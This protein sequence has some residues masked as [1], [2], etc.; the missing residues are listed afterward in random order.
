MCQENKN[1]SLD[2]IYATIDSIYAEHPEIVPVTKEQP[3]VAAPQ[4]AKTTALNLTKVVQE[5]LNE[6]RP[7]AALTNYEIK[8]LSEEEIQVLRPVSERTIIELISLVCGKGTKPYMLDGELYAHTADGQY[9]RIVPE[10]DGDSGYARYK[11]TAINWRVL[12][13]LIERYCELLHS[14]EKYEDIIGYHRSEGEKYFGITPEY[15]YDTEGEYNEDDCDCREDDDLAT[16]QMLNELLKARMES[17]KVHLSLKSLSERL[18]SQSRLYTEDIELL[19]YLKIVKNHVFKELERPW[20]P[21]PFTQYFDTL[22]ISGHYL[23]AWVYFPD[24]YNAKINNPPLDAQGNIVKYTVDH[25]EWGVEHRSN[26]SPDNLSIELESYN[27][28]R[29]RRSISVEY[30]GNKYVS[31]ST[32]CRDTGAG[33]ATNINTLKNST[34]QGE[35]F[36]YNVRTYIKVSDT[37]LIATDKVIIAKVPQ[38]MFNGTMYDTI[39]DFARAIK[40]TPATVRQAVSRA[41]AKEADKAEFSCK[42][43]NKKYQFYLDNLGNII[44]IL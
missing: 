6:L 13:R 24:E 3:P 20:C 40:L 44:K 30:Q 39:A 10:I 26:N 37:Q 42:L 23:S 29:T 36:E 7:T 16:L 21:V 1:T 35:T 31:L 34:E 15:D 28:G 5:H 38:I 33:N 4:Q 14:T 17:S 41:K 12:N 27:K 11:F 43:S 25:I 2:E 9:V 22:R 32:Y 19:Q 8:P 18:A